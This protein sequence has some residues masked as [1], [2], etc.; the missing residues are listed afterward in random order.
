[1]TIN[2]RRDRTDSPPE[3]M[4]CAAG[5]PHN[6]PLQE[7]RSR[8]PKP[9]LS[10]AALVL[11]GHAASRPDGMVLPPPASLRARGG[12]LARV[13]A[14]LLKGGHIAELQVSSEE[15]AWRRGDDG[16]PVG[17]RITEAGSMAIGLPQ[18]EPLSQAAVDEAEAT[19]GTPISGPVEQIGGD[20]AHVVPP[21]T[22]LVAP[23]SN[24]TDPAAL[25]S[26]RPTKQDQLIALLS[27]PD[28]QS[29]AALGA[30]LGWQPHTVRAALTGLRQKSLDLQKSKDEGG[31]TVYH[32]GPL[33]SRSPD[34]ESTLR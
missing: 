17:C 19:A 32:I 14:S 27:D 30:I 29:V 12:A 6:A 7:R 3:P 5:S 25:P 9:R 8:R 21:A 23:A 4:E 15:Q 13:L 11:L 22:D 18:A 24:Q 33:Q 1:M 10:N 20:A 34:W 16:E 26:R 28:G 31:T 2:H